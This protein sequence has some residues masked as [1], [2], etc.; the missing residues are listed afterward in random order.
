M[1]VAYRIV[2]IEPGDAFLMVPPARITCP[3]G[4]FKMSN[5]L[6]ANE[7]REQ[8]QKIM[9]GF[10]TAMLVTR[11]ENGGMH[12][13][14][15][16]IAE[17]SNAEVLYFATSAD[18]TKVS[19]VG[20]DPHVNI[21]MQDKR[22]F[23]SITGT[24]KVVQDRALIDRL[25]AETW[26]IWFPEGKSDPALCVLVVDPSEASYWDG[27]GV[28]GLKFLFEAAKAYLTGEDGKRKHDDRQS[29]SVKL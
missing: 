1:I 17:H 25:W 6:N 15:L 2:V 23:V 26:K 29:A 7:R 21:T 16:A 8:L 24:A 18:S 11:G 13:R 28:Q 20:V 14:P 22:R 27:E 3:Q 4:G 19:E 12:S 9:H 5:R 10:D